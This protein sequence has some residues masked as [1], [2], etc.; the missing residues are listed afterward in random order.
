MRKLTATVIAGAAT[1]AA[2]TALHAQQGM[3]AP[4]GKHD[5]TLVTAGTYTTD[6]NHSQVLFT[7]EHFGLTHNMG[8]ASGAK[9]TLTL[10]PANPSAASVSVDVPINTIHTTIAALDEEFQGPMFFD[11]AKFPVAHFESTG[12]TVDGESA[13]IA[14]NFTIKGVT[15]PGVIHAKF[16]AA[17]ANPFNK[18]D[19]VAFSG[20]STIKRSEFGLGNAVPLVGDDVNLTITVAFEKQ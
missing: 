3:P 19:T 17:G 14:G 8:L 7:Y 20:T 9:G 6:P 13:D 1:L 11:A 4:P 15:K 5:A 12:V 10:D 18:K 2:A 16:V